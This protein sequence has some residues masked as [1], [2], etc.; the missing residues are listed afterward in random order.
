M[1]EKKFTRRKLIAGV[2]ALGGLAVTGCDSSTLLPPHR[3]HGLGGV[4][5]AL[6]MVSH[7]L[8]ANENSI[9][10]EFEP[11]DITPHF[12]V[13]GTAFPE[14][15]QYRRQLQ[16]GFADFRLSVSG[17]VNKPRAFSLAEL[18]AMPSRTQITSHSCEKGWT[19]IAKW[20]GVQLRHLLELVG[21]V[22]PPG[23][24]VQFRCVDGWVGSI[25][26]GDARHVQTILAYHMNDADVP[27]PHGA[28]LRLRVERQMGYKSLKYV[29][30]I[31]VIEQPEGPGE[32]GWHWYAG[33]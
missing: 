28:P 9:K 10:P 7:R 5:E 8:F 6:N 21:G 22:Q 29:S 13:E 12:P 31:E 23:Q 2:S 11:A 30:A 20:Q 1:S 24:Y 15:E 25:D 17:L 26:M 32:S 3:K 4:A 19:A 33:A 27:I 18:R 14:D 16:D